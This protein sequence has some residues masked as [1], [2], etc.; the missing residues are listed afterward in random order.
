MELRTINIGSDMAALHRNSERPAFF[1]G[2]LCVPDA[3]LPP[4]GAAYRANK[5]DTEG[6]KSVDINDL[7]T[8]ELWR[9]QGLVEDFP[10]ALGE[11]SFRVPSA[12]SVLSANDARRNLSDLQETAQWIAG[13]TFG[14][15]VLQSLLGAEV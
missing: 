8:S 5:K 15:R 12:R 14:V 9:L 3:H 2:W 11:A 6:V 7:T 10:S 13:P 1:G 4:K